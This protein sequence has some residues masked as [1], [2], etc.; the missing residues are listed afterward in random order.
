MKAYRRKSDGKIAST[1][2]TY[3]HPSGKFLKYYYVIP[4]EPENIQQEEVDNTDNWEVIEIDDKTRQPTE[5][6][7][8]TIIK[9]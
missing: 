6:K 3:E 9:Q 2:G 4:G 1:Y 8:I 7:K 5:N